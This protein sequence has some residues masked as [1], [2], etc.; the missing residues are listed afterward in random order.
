MNVEKHIAYW[1]DGA[2]IAWR[3][4]PYPRD[5]G[6]FTEAL[7]WVHL[8]VEKALKA[9]VVKTTLNIPPYT[10]NLVRLAE[11]AEIVLDENDYDICTRLTKFQGG[12]RYPG[13]KEDKE[14]LAELALRVLNESERIWQLLLRKL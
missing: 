9:H 2:P 13:M 10:H 5:Q 7:F 11:L 1:R 14:P 8:A 4:V 3:T 6:F 12:G